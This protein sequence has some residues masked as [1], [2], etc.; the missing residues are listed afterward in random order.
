MQITFRRNPK[1]VGWTRRAAIALLV[2]FGTM[3]M[4]LPFSFLFFLSHYNS[5]YPKDTQNMLSAL[6]A[7]MLVGL[8][9]AVLSAVSSVVV[10]LF[11]GL[12]RTDSTS[13][14]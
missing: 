12:R 14:I 3:L 9:F 7:A 10:S 8:G 6:T 4:S 5:V 11:F 2:G 13:A 1:T